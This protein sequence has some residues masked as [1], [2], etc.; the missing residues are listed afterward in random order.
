[1]TKE[2]K[3]YLIDTETTISD[4]IPVTVFEIILKWLKEKGIQ[5]TSEKRPYV[6]EAKHGKKILWTFSS[7]KMEKKYTFILNETEAGGTILRIIMDTSWHYKHEFYLS[8]IKRG[9]YRHLEPLYKELGV[10]PDSSLRESLFGIQGYH[11]EMI[12]SMRNV[13]LGLITMFL[14]MAFDLWGSFKGRDIDLGSIII[15]MGA[16]T[17][18]FSWVNASSAKSNLNK[19][20]P[21]EKED[22]LRDAGDQNRIFKIM[23]VIS[24]VSIVGF[25]YWINIQPNMLIYSGLGYSFEYPKNWSTE[26]S[27]APDIPEHLFEMVHCDGDQEMIWVFF[28][29]EQSV[30]NIEKV[31]D[32]LFEEYETSF[33]SIIT[34]D[35]DTVQINSYKFD[36]LHVIFEDETGSLHGFFGFTHVPNQNRI[37]VIIYTS[38]SASG[39]TNFE[40]LLNSLKTS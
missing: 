24:L 32:T 27:Y 21:Q 16:V 17:A 12:D 13:Y 19:F 14:G 25:G 2:L 1:M 38:E 39:V 11:K 20:D 35:E 33:I 29:G 37:Y 22:F 5:V 15:P 36:T 23:T 18:I 9:W 7:E 34:L 30:N 3:P 6:I 26:V 31:R 28:Y 40:E 8:R 4:K 10:E